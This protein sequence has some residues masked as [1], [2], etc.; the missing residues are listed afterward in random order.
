MSI[1]L[2]WYQRKDLVWNAECT[3]GATLCGVEDNQRLDTEVWHFR[4]ADEDRA[5]GN[6]Y[7]PCG[8][9]LPTEDPNGYFP[10]PPIFR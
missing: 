10:N 8:P 9:K 3:C 5:N 2:I 4:C 7:K 6:K 1:R